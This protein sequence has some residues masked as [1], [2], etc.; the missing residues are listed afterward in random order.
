MTRRGGIILNVC[1][2][3]FGGDLLRLAELASILGHDAQLLA[4]VEQAL[5]QLAVVRREVAVQ[6]GLVSALN[7]EAGD[8]HCSCDTAAAFPESGRQSDAQARLFC[9]KLVGDG[10]PSSFSFLGLGLAGD[11]RGKCLFL[12]GKARGADERRE[13]GNSMSKARARL[14]M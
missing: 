6:Q 4:R 14:L 1:L 13:A 9:S 7:D 12:L 3:I 5:G 10:N 11:W 2:D 8:V